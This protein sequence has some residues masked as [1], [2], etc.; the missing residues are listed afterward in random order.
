MLVAGD[1]GGTKTILTLVDPKRG[2]RDPLYEHTFLSNEFDCLES[3]IREFWRNAGAFP[4]YLGEKMLEGSFGVAGPVVDGRAQLSNLPWAIDAKMLK[5]NLGW[6]SVVLLNDL[7]A[8][9][10][11]VSQLERED[12]VSLY[13]PHNITTGET[14]RGNIALVAPGTGL[15]EAFLTYISSHEVRKGLVEGYIASASEGGHTEFAPADDEQIELLRFLLQRYEHVSYER[16]ISG[17]GIPNI[18]DFFHEGRRYEEPDQFRKQ[19]LDAGTNGQDITPLILDA[20]CAS[21]N[22]SG[23]KCLIAEAVL[24]LFVKVLG[25]E[26]GNMALKTNAVGGVFLA[27]GI[28]PRILDVLQE[29]D[30]LEAYLAKGRMRSV[31]ERMPVSVI[32]NPKS[33]L[34]GAVFYG[35]RLRP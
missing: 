28:P 30:F 26:A 18:Y 1:I 20:A 31:V 8:L 33:A 4:G 23:P 10:W 34:L 13:S 12:T 2:A 16:V 32:V 25:A 27:G 22:G 6:K 11:A 9:A 19:I 35:L 29:G 5:T 15:G 24:K 14:N 3:M 7:E 17:L 21:R